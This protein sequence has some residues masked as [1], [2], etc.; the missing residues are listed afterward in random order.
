MITPEIT[1]TE[2]IEFSR[3][4]AETYEEMVA[5]CQGFLVCVQVIKNSE[6]TNRD[7]LDFMNE[8]RDLTLLLSDNVSLED[9]IN[10]M[11]A[12]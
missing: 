2:L 11:E 8:M 5:F 3:G 4:Y 7:E 1:K 10:L 9:V 12:K 6:D